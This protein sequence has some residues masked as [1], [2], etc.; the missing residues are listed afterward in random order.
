MLDAHQVACL[1]GHQDLPFRDGGLGA[2]VGGNCRQKGGQLVAALLR[3]HDIEDGL[4]DLR[5]DEFAPG[6]SRK[7]T[8]SLPGAHV[9]VLS[10]LD[11]FK[12]H[13]FPHQGNILIAHLP[14]EAV[15]PLHSDHI[16]DLIGGDVVAEYDHQLGQIPQ[17]RGVIG[18]QLTQDAGPAHPVAGVDGAGGVQVHQP[19]LCVPHE[20]GQHRDLD[21]AGRG[22]HMLRVDGEDLAGLAVLHIEAHRPGQS[23]EDAIDFILRDTFHENMPPVLFP[24]ASYRM[25]D[26][27]TARITVP[28]IMAKYESFII[29]LMLLA[30]ASPICPIMSTPG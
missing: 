24:K 10:L 25:N 16:H 17:G 2:G 23:G 29:G 14:A 11:G 3:C 7:Q 26:A 12:I 20:K 1:V 5:I 19:L 18:A 30:W 6:D 15:E 13:H 28:G 9:V 4:G 8:P 27:S 21:D 22:K